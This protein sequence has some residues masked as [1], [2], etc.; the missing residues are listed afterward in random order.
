[1]NIAV[2]DE[3]H[4]FRITEHGGQSYVSAMSGGI[5]Q[6]EI[7]ITLDAQEVAPLLADKAKRIALAALMTPNSDEFAE[8][9]VALPS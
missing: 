3:D 6:Y 2:L 7:T 9:Q 8:R 5:N 1:M 4:R